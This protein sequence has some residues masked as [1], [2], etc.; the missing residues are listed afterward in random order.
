MHASR[1]RAGLIMR[2]AVQQRLLGCLIGSSMLGWASLNN[3]VDNEP[4]R[5]RLVPCH[6]V[7]GIRNQDS[8]GYGMLCLGMRSRCIRWP[9]AGQ[10][11]NYHGALFFLHR[12]NTGAAP[13]SVRLDLFQ[14]PCPRATSVWAS[15]Y[16]PRTPSILALASACIPPTRANLADTCPHREH[17]HRW[18]WSRLQCQ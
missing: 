4:C 17:V 3:R 14:T 8:D 9:H 2:S 12:K 1:Q 7:H 18:P 16:I 5:M 10:V 13:F 11:E 6:Q 15:I